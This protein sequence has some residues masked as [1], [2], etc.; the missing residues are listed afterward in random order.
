M[1][2]N[3]DTDPIR[4][5]PTSKD[6]MDQA[7][8]ELDSHKQEW[9]NLPIDKRI[10]ILEDVQRDFTNVM[11][12]WS[13]W[14]VLAKGI[15]E[16]RLGN[17]MEWLEIAVIARIHSVVHRA[18]C[19]IRDHGHPRIPGAISVRP[20][21]RVKVQVYP[22][23]RLHSMLFRGIT[24]EVWIEPGIDIDE[25]FSGQAEKYNDESLIGGVALVLGA[26]NASPLPPS[27]VFHKLF[28]DLRVVALK[29]NPVNSY[30]GPLLEE[31]Y[32]SLIEKGYLR[33][34]YGGA[35]EGSYLVGHPL[36]GEGHMTGSDRTFDTI[37]FGS[38]EDGVRRKKTRNPLVRK[39]FTGELGC[40]T[41]WVVVP[42]QWKKKDVETAA[43]RMAFWITRHEGYLCFAPRVLVLQQDWEH[44]R[45]F[46]DILAESLKK[47]ETIQAYYPGSIELQRTFVREHPDAI[48][49]GGSD[50]N[51]IPW[52]IIEGVDAN[53]AND[54]CFRM[55]S[56]SGLCAETSLSASSPLEFLDL[57]VKF[58]NDTVW[59]NLSVTLVA[60]KAIL[61][62]PKMSAAIEGAIADLQY[63]TVALNGPGTWG[64]YGMSAPWGAFPGNDIFD[65][66]SGIGKVAN[67]LML[68]KVEKTV[69]RASL[70]SSPYPFRVD[71]KNLDTFC[72]KLAHFEA[73]QSFGKLLGLVWQ[74]L[75]M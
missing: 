11:D 66:Q 9:V 17:D 52:T 3:S 42:G 24:H 67:F 6:A 39:P 53:S 58:L 36:V 16:R 50:E 35:K 62:D 61:R 64:F 57:A 8:M 68:P 13:Q 2:L 18:L 29:M 27:D 31:A 12:R 44:R 30:L 55:E 25:V 33:I 74:A 51:H 21:G 59:G 7:L 40:I 1:N 48:E 32:R 73:N 69:V 15:A 10:S 4:P 20:D 41:P 47:V 34:L 37:I 63:G 14:S 46:L 38:G 26:G 5:Q 56:F 60:N 54:I 22:D 19:D 49:I 65:I 45:V 23:S 43:S 72:K 75:R 28:H 70:E 71:A